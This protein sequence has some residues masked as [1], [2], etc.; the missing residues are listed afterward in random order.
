MSTMKLILT[1]IFSNFKFICKEEPDDDVNDII[2]GFGH[3]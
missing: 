2:K 1:C 3:I